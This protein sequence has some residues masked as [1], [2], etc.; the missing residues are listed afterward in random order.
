METGCLGN[1]LELPRN[2]CADSAI[3]INGGSE[4]LRYKNCLMEWVCIREDGSRA[5]S[6]STSESNL[7]GG[8]QINGIPNQLIN[9]LISIV[10]L[11][12]MK[13]GKTHLH[14]VDTKGLG[15]LATAEPAAHSPVLC[16]CQ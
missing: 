2:Y 15:P 1:L 4:T 8:G 11:D 9:R 7:K 5:Q 16:F 6:L 13:G 10:L 14:G 12:R 3:D